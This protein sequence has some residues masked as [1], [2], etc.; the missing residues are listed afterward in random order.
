MAPLLFEWL[1]PGGTL[2]NERSTRSYPN[3]QTETA[4]MHR[5]TSSF[6][7]RVLGYF[8]DFLSLGFKRVL[9]KIKMASAAHR[10]IS[11]S[12]SSSNSMIFPRTAV[13][14]A[15][16][17]PAQPPDQG[18]PLDMSGE[19]PAT[20]V[21]LI[22]LIVGVPL[23]FITIMWMSYYRGSTRAQRR[24]KPLSAS[25]A[26]H[27]VFV[28]GCGMRKKADTSKETTAFEGAF[29]HEPVIE[30]GMTT[31]SSEV[32]EP[33]RKDSNGKEKAVP[34]SP[35][36]THRR[37]FAPSIPPQ[38]RMDD[39]SLFPVSIGGSTL[40]RSEHATDTDTARV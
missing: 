4:L 20:Q 18:N 27:F 35:A 11:S 10:K 26:L 31:P 38:D 12:S 24:F 13:V 6:L 23:F 32:A 22:L 9:R 1:T 25:T 28:R 2:I 3:P 40:S 33:T 29:S 34:F 37:S 30:T 15:G 19:T 36:Q 21:I 16:T 39:I 7:S 17:G 5:S 8:D 14:G